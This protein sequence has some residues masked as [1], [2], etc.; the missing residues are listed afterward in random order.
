MKEQIDKLKEHLSFLEQSKNI[1]YKDEP[2][3]IGILTRNESIKVISEH[4]LFLEKI[5]R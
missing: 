1:Q 3:K 2:F 4:L 5:L